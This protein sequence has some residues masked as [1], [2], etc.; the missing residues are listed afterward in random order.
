MCPARSA[1]FYLNTGSPAIDAGNALANAVGLNLKTTQTNNLPDAA[2]VD[3]GYHYT[4]IRTVE[5]FTLTAS[6]VGGHGNIAPTTGT[7][8]K[9]Q[10]VMVSAI[11]DATYRVEQWGGGTI[12]DNSKQITNVVI[13]DASKHVTV[14]YD[15]PRVLVVGSTPRYTDIQRTIMDAVDGD[16][17]M[18]KPGQYNPARHS[19]LM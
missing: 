2:A 1:R 10:A 5:S 9:G 4:D 15:Q 19:R 12:N 3:L 6:V 17:V 13:M 11:P 18:V 8:Y 16:I 14:Q 7:Y